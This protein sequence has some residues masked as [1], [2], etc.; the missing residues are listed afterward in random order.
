MWQV[1]FAAFVV[2]TTIFAAL[3]LLGFLIYAGE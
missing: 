2:P 3:P 1:C